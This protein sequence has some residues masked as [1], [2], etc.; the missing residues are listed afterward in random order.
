MGKKIVAA[1][2]LPA[3]HAIR[4]EDL[5]VKC[6]GDGLPPH[7]IDKV[8]GRTTLAGGRLQSRGEGPNTRRI[9]LSPAPAFIR[10]TSGPSV[11]DR[12]IDPH[13]SKPAAIGPN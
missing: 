10:Q 11:P 8:V 5:T 1:R 4:R 9:Q 7:E 6:P 2:K 3:G 13:N 12:K